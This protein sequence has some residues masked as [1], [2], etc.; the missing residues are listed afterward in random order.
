[1]TLNLAGILVALAVG[2]I[3]EPNC[4]LELSGLSHLPL[5]SHAKGLSGYLLEW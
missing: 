5:L 4:F 1:M 2:L 3:S